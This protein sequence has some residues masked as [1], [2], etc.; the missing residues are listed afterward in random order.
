MAALAVS[1]VSGIFPIL[2]A[3]RLPPALAFRKVVR[4]LRVAGD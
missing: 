4:N 1:T 2:E 3:V